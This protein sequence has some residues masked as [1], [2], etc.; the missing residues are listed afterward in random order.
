MEL[1]EASDTESGQGRNEQL[2]GEQG[3]PSKAVSPQPAVQGWRRD[4]NGSKGVEWRPTHL[5]KA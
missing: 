3:S 1:S 4:K 5:E 2:H